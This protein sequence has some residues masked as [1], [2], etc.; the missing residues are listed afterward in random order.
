MF[1]VKDQSYDMFCIF[2]GN[3]KNKKGS[4]QFYLNHGSS[5]GIYLNTVDKIRDTL[6]NTTD[7]E[8]LLVISCLAVRN[9]PAYLFWLV[10]GGFL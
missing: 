8:Y 4:H 3:F 7:W 2:G 9:P 5:T 10:I 6:L 1:A